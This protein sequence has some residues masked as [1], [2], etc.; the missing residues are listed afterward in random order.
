MNA[1]FGIASGQRIDGFEARSHR[2]Q[3]I[4]D[5]RIVTP[6][7]T[8]HGANVAYTTD[9]GA[10]LGFAQDRLRYLI[11]L[12][13][14]HRPMADWPSGMPLDNPDETARRLL[15]RY[16]RLKERFLDGI[17]GQFVLVLYDGALKRLILAS[18]PAGSRSIFYRVK[19]DCIE[20]STNLVSMSILCSDMKIDRTIEDFLLGYEFLPWDRTVFRGVKRL[21]KGTILDFQNGRATSTGTVQSPIAVSTAHSGDEKSVIH[22]LHDEFMQSLESML[23]SSGPVA[24]LLGGFDSALIAAGLVRL[25]RKFESFTFRFHDE[26]YNQ[27]HVET[28]QRHLGHRHTW[29]EIDSNVIRAGLKHYPL[30]FNQPAGQMHYLIETAHACRVIRDSGY[31]HC[32]TG[33]GCDEVF[34]GYPTVH[35]RAVLFQRLGRLPQSFTTA[36]SWPLKARIAERHLG[37]VARL[38]R[39]VINILGRHMPVRGHISSRV[40]DEISLD[41]LRHGIRP[42]QEKDV[43]AILTELA[44]GL[45][46][47]SP[48]RLAYHGKSSVGLNKMKVE[49]SS[50]ASG[51][52]IQSPY[53]HPGLARLARNLPDELLRP[54]AATQGKAMGKHVLMRMAETF[55]LLPT[56]VIYQ[57]K[58]SPVA[59]PVDD[60]Y[61]GDLKPDLLAAV[62]D[63]P[64]DYDMSYIDDLLKPKR[65]EELFRNHVGLGR[66]AF[67]AIS[68]LATYASFTRYGKP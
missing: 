23:P 65:A 2:V 31:R 25:G 66:Y 46:G 27:Q 62:R 38:G 19:S 61:M 16:D 34:L 64:F 51:L 50:A 1:I 47:L 63:L 57:P 10:I 5:S 29:V 53:Q 68:L 45:E 60:W 33:D 41:Y 55:Q 44:A 28:L 13:V 52:T 9:G 12:G 18:D 67:H 26:G 35:Q 59:A 32:L 15:A 22:A 36:A 6:A 21:S 39:N 3:E 49:G 42:Q 48:L 8:S 7:G 4:F 11:Y 54:R 14:F 24:L 20:F 43:E 37:H 40:F 56:E 17:D 30:W 58:A